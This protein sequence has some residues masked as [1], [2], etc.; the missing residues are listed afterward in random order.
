MRR[1]FFQKIAPGLELIDQAPSPQTLPHKLWPFVFYFVKQVRWPVAALAVLW[2]FGAIMYSLIPLAIGKVAGSLTTSDLQNGWEQFIFFNVL[3]VASLHFTGA[4]AYLTGSWIVKNFMTP[5]VMSIRRQLGQ[6]VYRHS[7][8]YFQDDY[9][10]SLAG[11]IMEMPDHF[12]TLI[13]IATQQANFATIHFIMAFVVFLFSGWQFALTVLLYTCCCAAVIFVVGKR[14]SKAGYHSAEEMN[15]VRGHYIDSISNIFLVKVFSRQHREDQ[16][17]RS[18]LSRAGAAGQKND[19]AALAME[20]S[21]YIINDSFIIV[22]LTLMLFGYKDGH[23]GVEQFVS[24]MTYALILTQQSWWLQS[25]IVQVFRLTA[26][27]KNSIDTIVQNFDIQDAPDAVPLVVKRGEI[28]IKNVH[29]GY[30]SRPVFEGLNLTIHAGEKVGLVGPSGAGKSTLIQLLLRLYDLQGGLI[31][32]DGQ[33]IAGVTQ[34]SLRAPFAVI[35]QNAEL[36]HRTILENIKFGS[37]NA[38]FEAVQ[39]A[40]RLAHAEDFI[41]SLVDK[42]G[43]KAYDAEVGERGVKLS[44]GQKQRIALARAILKNSPILILDEATSAL[45]SQSEKLIEESLKNITQGRT[46]VA[47]AHRLSTLRMMDRII[48][49]DRGQIVESGSHDDLLAQNGLY[50]RLWTLQTEGFIK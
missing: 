8:R 42:N 15:V 20:A 4:L 50:A 21:Q 22:L 2:N 23:I 49:M 13:Y 44:G 11:K 27:M 41:L 12:R 48:V 32:I 40:A 46:V 33:D 29:F 24:M 1:S 14:V 18:V 5:F 16:R 10:G 47:I 35:S 6:Y 25:L 17:M 3:M 36:F 30:P 26:E 38:D 19:E 45:D 31:A 7:Y 39:K 28:E 34:D 43:A 37:E 9:V